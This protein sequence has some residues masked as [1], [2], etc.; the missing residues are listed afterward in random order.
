M[1][2]IKL[3]SMIMHF[4]KKELNLKL[5]EDSDKKKFVETSDY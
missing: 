5:S 3:F 2:L 4:Q 1:K